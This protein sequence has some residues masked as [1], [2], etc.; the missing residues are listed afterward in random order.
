MADRRYEHVTTDQIRAA[1][2]ALGLDVNQLEELSIRRGTV[3]VRYFNIP[4]EGYRMIG[5]PPDPTER[6]ITYPICEPVTTKEF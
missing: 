3:T 2:E 5:D 6:T 1:C 4:P